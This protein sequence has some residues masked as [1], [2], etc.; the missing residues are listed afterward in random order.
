MAIKSKTK[1]D[2]ACQECGHREPR[3]V[4]KC[5]ACQAWNSLVEETKTPSAPRAS[6]AL[7]DFTVSAEVVP[8]AA[9]ESGDGEI[10]VASSIGELDRVLGGGLVRGSV[11][12]LGGDPGIGK[13]TLALQLA[14][15]LTRGGNGVLYVAGEEAPTQIRLRAE[16]LGVARERVSVLPATDVNAIVAAMKKTRPA[17]AIIDS[18]QTIYTKRVDSAPGSVTQLREST[19][20]L[21]VAARALEVALLVIGH[22]TKEGFLAGPRVLEHMVDT[23]LYF[24]GERHGG[25]RILRAVKNRFGPTGEIGVFEMRSE[26]L[27][28]VENPSEVLAGDMAREIAGSVVSAAMEGTRPVL[29]EIQ[30]LVAPSVPGSARRTTLGVDHQRVAMLAAVMEKHMGLAMIQHDLFVNTAGGVRI[31]DPGVDLAVVAALASSYLERPLAPGS[32]VLGEVGLTGEVRAV[33][34]IEA[35]LAEASR[36]GVKRAIIPARD[37]ERLGKRRPKGMEL[38][39]IESAARAAEVLG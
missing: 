38:I 9:I 39:G 19:A 5:P 34:R 1:T 15:G 29:V 10:R 24:E 33:S 7:G 27:A 23:V 25:F 35:R 30:A 16:R 31:D 22:V 6:A 36:L 12:L 32:L 26:G 14:G 11:V 3:W 21:I 17:L 28:E 4:G 8:L 13:S 20:E 18:V 37:V 2:Y